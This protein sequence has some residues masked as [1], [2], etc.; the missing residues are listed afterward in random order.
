MKPDTEVPRDIDG[1]IARHP[2]EVQARLAAL[3]ATIRR[4]APAAE[5][6]ISYRMPT[7]YLG[8]NLVHFAAFERHVGFYPGAAAIAAFQKNIARYKNGKGSVQFPHAE[9]LPLHLV[10]AILAFVV[11]EH[12]RK[13]AAKGATRGPQHPAATR[14]TGARKK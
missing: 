11:V 1:Y 2:P 3:R 14:A 9:P 6:R 7:F 10:D 12:A 4:H 8:G 13:V 5:E